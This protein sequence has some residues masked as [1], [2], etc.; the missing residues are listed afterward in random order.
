MKKY[1]IFLR[2]TI[3]LIFILLYLGYFS[4]GFSQQKTNPQQQGK[5]DSTLKILTD[6]KQL[7][8]DFNDDLGN[9][10][11]ISLLSPT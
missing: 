2:S 7:S 5:P 3:S 10:R 1:V 11:L 4:P 8:Q 9:V 6:F